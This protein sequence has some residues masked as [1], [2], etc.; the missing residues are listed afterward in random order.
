[1]SNEA[2]LGGVSNEAML[3]DVWL[4]AHWSPAYSEPC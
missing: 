4:P 1:V 3:N 2:M